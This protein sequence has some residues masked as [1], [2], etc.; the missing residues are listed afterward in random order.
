MLTY[1]HVAWIKQRVQ[2]RKVRDVVIIWI[3]QIKNYFSMTYVQGKD[4]FLFGGDSFRSEMGKFPI[5]CWRVTVLEC[6]D[7]TV[8]GATVQ[9]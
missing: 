8:S 6:A 7:H 1:V 5:K 2:A 9:L 4:G 3:I